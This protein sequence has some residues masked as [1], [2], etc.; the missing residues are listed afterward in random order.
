MQGIE[1]SSRAACEEAPQ[2]TRQETLPVMQGIETQSVA[3]A[4]Y[5][6]GRQETLPVMQGIE[7]SISTSAGQ[8][9]VT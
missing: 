8:F 3:H 6:G 7:T 4:C 1:T 9:H 5:A 2:R